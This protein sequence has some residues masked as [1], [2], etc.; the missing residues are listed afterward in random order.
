[1]KRLTVSVLSLSLT[2]C[3]LTQPEPA[4]RNTLGELDLAT[5][6]PQT[7]VTE[8]APTPE[9]LAAAYQEIV[10]LAPK[11]SARQQ[12]N[13]RLAQLSLEQQQLAQEQG[14]TQDSGYFNNTVNQYLSLIHISE[15]TRPC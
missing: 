3:F 15:P 11:A 9:Q 13:S 8:A 6:L 10:A 2:A 1:M 4:K 12:A 5:E 14:V 7:T